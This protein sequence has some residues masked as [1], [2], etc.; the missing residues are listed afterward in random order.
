M[1]LTRMTP[2]QDRGISQWSSRERV[3]H[4]TKDQGIEV[5]HHFVSELWREHGLQPHVQATFTLSR[6]PRGE[7]KVADGV[8]GVPGPA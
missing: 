8:G 3:T 6:D 4:V 1:A 5:S 2:P 7:E